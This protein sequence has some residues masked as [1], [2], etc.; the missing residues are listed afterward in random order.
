MRYTE[1][2]YYGT[3]RG[4]PA[5]M[6]GHQM[7]SPLREIAVV[8]CSCPEYLNGT[9]KETKKATICKKCRG[10]RLPLA[11]IGGTV[12]LRSTTPMVHAARGSAGTVRLP[13]A[14]NFKQRPSILSAES[15]P[16]DMMRRS[17]LVSPELQPVNN[18][19]KSSTT[20]KNRAKSSS[21]S[22]SRSRTRKRTPSPQR[23]YGAVETRSRSASRSNS[24][25]KDT[26]MEVAS[27]AA[28]NRRSILQC[29]LSAYEL[30][31]KI[32][33]NN[34][35]SPLGDD[36]MY[37][38]QSQRYE[39]YLSPSAQQNIDSPAEIAAIGGQRIN[40]SGGV[41]FSELLEDTN[42]MYAYE[43][44]CYP[45][46]EHS[47]TASQ[48]SSSS[49]SIRRKNDAISPVRPP[50]STRQHGS[51]DITV[52]N[53]SP[54]IETSPKSE[55]VLTHASLSHI[56]GE[57][58]AAQQQ[59]HII[60]SIL[61]RPPPLP[62]SSISSSESSSIDEYD[63]NVRAAT[64]YHKKLPKTSASSD[65]KTAKGKVSISLGR[66][67]MS[68][69]AS[70][71]SSSNNNTNANGD[72]EKRNSGSHFYLPMPQRKKVQFLVENEIIYDN[73]V[74]LPNQQQHSDVEGVHR[75]DNYTDS[76]R[77]FNNN[78][79][80]VVIG[81]DGG[82]G[83]D[84]YRSAVT[85]STSSYSDVAIAAD[86]IWPETTMMMMLAK[87]ATKNL[88]FGNDADDGAHEQNVITE[89]VAA[90][91]TVPMNINAKSNETEIEKTIRTLTSVAANTT[92]VARGDE[93][94][95]KHLNL[96]ILT[97]T[98]T[99]C[100]RNVWELLNPMLVMIKTHSKRCY[101][102]TFSDNLTIKGVCQPFRNIF[103]TLYKLN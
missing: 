24:W 17:R 4:V 22:R 12:R 58:A 8:I 78:S 71:A 56:S 66:N 16:Y 92:S 45:A 63:A 49:S 83:N 6:Q 32:S 89:T 43:K 94:K 91:E 9:K 93:G 75:I 90:S 25:L 44:L 41:K 85:T 57:M 36:D 26:D 77:P 52:E 70:I 13:S 79:V 100:V 84:D 5:P 98:L 80:V 65:N 96:F 10:S 73:L 46:S 3:V 88:I 55:F 1:P 72:K 38:M 53:K 67:A 37:S 51:G 14:Y 28:A 69:A 34:E 62:S 61:K 27:A 33:H 2:W 39:N 40:I 29:D 99:Q 54:V 103:D 102:Y 47:D 35:F 101:F 42:D 31:S 21:P 15:D 60:K 20:S 97:H 30:I 48:K 68:V 81:G 18:V 74:Q 76:M 19:L 50:R 11:P 95:G 59:V 64:M 86:S 23:H 7:F 82:A 87:D